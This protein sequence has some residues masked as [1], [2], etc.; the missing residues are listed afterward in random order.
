MTAR[1]EVSLDARQEVEVVA[2]SDRTKVI[3]ATT[4][5]TAFEF[6]EFLLYGALAANIGKQ[7]FSSVNPTAAYVF[8]L[9]AFAA[10]FIVRPLGAVVFGRVGDLV[11]RKYTFLITVVVMGVATIAVGIL[12]SYASIGIAA[13]IILICLRM[14]QGLALGGEYGGAAVYLAEHAPAG[15][16]NIFTAWLQLSS[17]LGLVMALTIVIACRATLTPEAFDA[18]G[19]RIPFVFSVVILAVSVWLRMSLRES[20]LFEDMKR[21][22]TESKA[23]LTESFARIDNLKVIL[24]ALFGIVAGMTVIWYGAQIYTL[25]F[26]T[27]VLKMDP[28]SANFVLT[29]AL[30]VGIPV[31]LAVGYVSDRVGRKP[32]ILAG[33]CLAALTIFPIFKGITHYTNPALERA[34]ASSPVL[35]LSDPKECSFQFNLVGTSKFTSSCDV[36]KAALTLRGIPY[37]NGPLPA[38]ETAQIVVGSSAVRSYDAVSADALERSKDFNQM[39]DSTLAGV[40]Y[41]ARANP[42][43][44]NYVMVTILIALLVMYAAIAYSPTAAA[45]VELFPTRIRYTS[46][47]L[48]YHLGVGWIGG[49]FPAIALAIQSETGSLYDGLWYALAVI[50]VS[51]VVMVLF[52]RETKDVNLENN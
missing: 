39:L 19:W 3:F 29:V 26:L 51:I 40:N 11:G 34:Q 27:R 6:Y 18:W 10:G 45:L 48:P 38:G 21:A 13:P 37:A 8:A 5:G 46:V 16:R 7:F 25:V 2:S 50:V 1:A 23:P 42:S 15:K 43:E 49:F 20:P 33:Y 47:S 32:V 22:G 14:L 31:Y 9:L 41:P 35:V 44:I 24:K 28:Q 12:P 30:L 52:V 17:T 4:I 36:A